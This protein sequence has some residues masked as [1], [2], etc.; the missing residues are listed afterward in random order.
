MKK[1]T[2]IIVNPVS[3]VRKKN[4]IGNYTEKILDKKKF[5][6]DIA[7]TRKAGHATELA[8]K[9]SEDNYE[10]VIAAGGDGTINEVAKGL[11][12]TK[13]SMGFIPIGSGNGLAH[14]LKIPTN[15][16]AA[17]EAI[18]SFNNKKIDT[19]RI[20]NEMFVSIAGIGFDA[21]V[22]RKFSKSKRRGFLAYFGIVS[23]EY[24]WYKPKKY[25]LLIDGKPLF[26][27]AL[28]ISFANSNQFGYNTQIAPDAKIDDGLVDVCIAHKVPLIELPIIAHL[29]YWNQ[30]GKSKYVEIIKARKIEVLQNRNR[31]IN[32]DGEAVK[33]G[34]HLKINIDPMSLNIIAP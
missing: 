18:N 12:H 30:I 28:L 3:G 24:P 20:N 21:R 26:K 14:H 31:Y 22:A 15:P 17:L 6:Y 34:K 25:Q 5:D 16:V 29:L 23:R 27:K 2:K 7:Y 1:K 10:L 9:A 33:L 4:I 32:L 19:V 13:T 8:R 11:V